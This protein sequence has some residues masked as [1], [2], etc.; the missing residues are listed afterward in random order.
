MYVT[1]L[2]QLPNGYFHAAA[3]AVSSVAAAAVVV[4]SVSAAT[5]TRHQ[6]LPFPWQYGANAIV[7]LRFYLSHTL[8]I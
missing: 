7:N 6:R 5:Q 3:V 2:Q 8:E 4:V 1:I